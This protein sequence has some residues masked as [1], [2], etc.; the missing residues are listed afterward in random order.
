M[1]LLLVSLMLASDAG[2][3]LDRAEEELKSLHRE[4]ALALLEQARQATPLTHAEHVRLY[5]QLGIVYAY[6]GRDQEAV[7]A[8]DMLLALSPGYALRYTLSPKV[9]FPF[10]QARSASAQRPAPE[11]RVTWPLGLQVSQPLPLTLEVASDPKG[12]LQSARVYWRRAGEAAFASATVPLAGRGDYRTLTLPSWPAQ[13]PET[14][15]LYAV[16]CDASG[17]EV[18]DVGS[19]RDPY[20]VALSFTKPPA[21]YQH[22]WV[23]AIAGVVVAGATGA[24]IYAASHDAPSTVPADVAFQR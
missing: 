14:V 2:P 3:L 13:G 22:W 21:W 4:Q 15:E 20:D 1:S 11:L 9:T 8:F 12:F 16:A 23:W 17:N 24:G 18:L 7:E 19:P 10:E 5:E 6:L